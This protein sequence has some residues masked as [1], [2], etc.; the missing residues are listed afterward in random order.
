MF[1]RYI[2][3]FDSL[4]INKDLELQAKKIYDII[5]SK[6]E[7]NEFNFIYHHNKKGDFNFK[8]VVVDEG[9]KWSLG[10]EGMFTND[11]RKGENDN[12]WVD[13]GDYKI[14]IKNRD[15]F[16]VL[17]H[18]MKH[19]DYIINNPV[20]NVDSLV[21]N[22]SKFVFNS[23]N[24][25][26]FKDS[27]GLRQIKAV[28][29]LLNPNEFEAKFHG[30]YADIDKF[31][32]KHIPDEPT[33]QY[34]VDLINI[35]LKAE[36]TDKSY[37]FWVGNNNYTMESFLNR[38]SLIKFYQ[39]VY[40][41]NDNNPFYSSSLEDF[42]K[43]TR[44]YIKSL[45][46]EYDTITEDDVDIL[47]KKC[48]KIIAKN[49]VKFQKKFHRIYTIMVDKYMTKKNNINEMAKYDFKD[50]R[51]ILKKMVDKYTDLKAG[52]MGTIRFTDDIGQIHVNWDNGSTLAL[53]P[54]VDDYEILDD[55]VVKYESKNET[56]RIKRFEG[57]V[58]EFNNNYVMAKMDELNDLLDG[59]KFMANYELDDNI[60]EIE[61]KYIVDDIK[62][63][64][65]SEY[66][67]D[68]TLLTVSYR[69]V[70]DSIGGLVNNEEDP[71]GYDKF[72]SI[73]EL[74]DFVI[75]DI[76]N[77]YLGIVEKINN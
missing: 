2:K 45:L 53:I 63:N 5:V 7:V 48:N 21:Y 72:G 77:D 65:S 47:I 55:K 14:T 61:V 11:F 16:Y 10:D 32:E 42:F 18:E 67:C 52:D 49:R 29:Y 71:V 44:R 73:E 64:M 60:L 51:V 57:F 30:Y 74:M 19:M 31:I 26:K 17:L 38:D 41:E 34:I 24:I 59:S 75:T 13:I 36:D 39:Y 50:R 54:G 35:Y 9:D 33:P 37:T 4:G 46:G 20:I 3:L 1:M 58:L 70:D 22:S 62:I 56:H 27:K 25:G 8:V 23:T 66:E 68:L 69:K 28:F 6:P 15:K 76:S 43:R 12:I 40:R